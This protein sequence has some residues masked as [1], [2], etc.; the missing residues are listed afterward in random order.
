MSEEL[1]V[2]IGEYVLIPNVPDEAKA[3]EAS[4]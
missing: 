1:T 3:V 2:P 4:L